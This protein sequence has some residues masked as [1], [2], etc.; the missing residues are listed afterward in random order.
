MEYSIHPKLRRTKNL[1]DKE[2]SRRSFL[3][4]VAASALSV[5]ATSVLSGCGTKPAAAPAPAP[6]TVYGAHSWDTAP[7]PIT[8]FQKTIDLTNQFLV[9]GAGMSGFAVAARSW[10]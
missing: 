3:K 6:A 9:I 4:G 1:S 2:I 10:G 7:A 8:E 5:A